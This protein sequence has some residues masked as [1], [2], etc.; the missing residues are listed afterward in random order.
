MMKIERAEYLQTLLNEK[1]IESLPRRYLGMSQIG[2]PC[3]R[4]LQYNFRWADTLKHD[5]R[6]DRLFNDGHLLEK[7]IIK[8]LESAGVCISETQAELIGYEYHAMG[9][10]DGVATNVPGHNPDTKFLLEIKT[11]NK[12]SFDDLVK[13]KVQKAKP[14]HYAQMTRYAPDLRCE[15]W[16]YVAY[17]KDNSAIYIEFGKVDAAYY[18]ELLTKEEDILIATTLLPKIGTGQKTWHECKFCSF[19]DVCHSDKPILKNCRTC[20]H[21]IVEPGGIWICGRDPDVLWQI[22]YS[23]QEF[24]CGQWELDKG[25]FDA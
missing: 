9:H 22:S 8:A 1:I 6:I 23:G 15:D 12:K 16:M 25:F 24:G 19:A 21:V 7:A 13:K 20:K 17:C 18:K 2:E 10:C 3:A 11:H 14:I 5:A 4:K